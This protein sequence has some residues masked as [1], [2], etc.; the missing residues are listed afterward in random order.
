MQCAVQ[1]TIIHFSCSWSIMFTDKGFIVQNGLSTTRVSPECSYFLNEVFQVH[2]SPSGQS[3]TLR[4]S[5][6]AEFLSSLKRSKTQMYQQI[7][8]D[9]LPKFLKGLD[10]ILLW[11][12]ENCSNMRNLLKCENCFS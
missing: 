9:F 1:V 10:L 7:P 5:S 2:S 3:C 12:R 4:S 11:F 6:Y 8:L